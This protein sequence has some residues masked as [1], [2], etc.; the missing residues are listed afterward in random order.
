MSEIA[1][2]L[3]HPGFDKPRDD[4][5]EDG[6]GAGYLENRMRHDFRDLCRL[7]GKENAR[8]EVAQIINAEFERRTIEHA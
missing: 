5:P 8:E 4:T 2:M 1:M 7:I 3:A 6:F